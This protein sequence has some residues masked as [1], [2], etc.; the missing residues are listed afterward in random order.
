MFAHNWSIQTFCSLKKPNQQESN[1]PLKEKIIVRQ[2]T[3]FRF[4]KNVPLS[5]IKSFFFFICKNEFSKLKFAQI[6]PIWFK[7]LLV[8]WQMGSP[9]LQILKELIPHYLRNETRNF[10][11]VHNWIWNLRISNSF[12]S[13]PTFYRPLSHRFCPWAH[14]IPLRTIHQ[15]GNL[16]DPCTWGFQ[17]CCLDCLRRWHGLRLSVRLNLERIFCKN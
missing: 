16:Q 12:K 3:G 15:A 11:F 14:P 9:R 10:Q 6:C 7:Y 5:I 1:Q 8:S 17:L 2:T 13:S 4:H